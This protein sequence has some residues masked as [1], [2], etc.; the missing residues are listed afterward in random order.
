MTTIQ[1]VGDADIM[2]QERPRLILMGREDKG[3][4]EKRIA[5]RA[6]CAVVLVRA[7]PL[8][9]DGEIRGIR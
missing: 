8:W 3:G 7:A 2:E 9:Q 6:R 4:W 5:E 1:Q